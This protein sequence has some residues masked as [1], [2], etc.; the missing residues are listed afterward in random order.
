MKGISP[1]IAAVL[2]VVITVVASI[3]LSGWLST[4]TSFQSRT[5]RNNT[6]AQLQC[7]YADLYIK[8]ATYDCGLNCTTGTQHTTTVTVVNSGKRTVTIDRLY[9]RNASGIVTSLLL[10]ESKTISV[11]NALTVTNTTRDTCTGI[12]NT[13]ELVEVNS[14]ECPSTA[15]DSL[16]RRGILYNNC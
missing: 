11:G 15:Y 8:N 4:T 13:I 3:F 7:Q 14:M 1:L 16:D 10:N 5:I 9:L 6:I 12:N 2:L